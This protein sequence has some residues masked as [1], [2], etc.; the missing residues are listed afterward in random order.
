[1]FRQRLSKLSSQLY[2]YGL[3]P[4]GDS[5]LLSS[6]LLS[7]QFLCLFTWIIGM[8]FSLFVSPF[9]HTLFSSQEWLLIITVFVFVS[10]VSESLVRLEGLIHFQINHGSLQIHGTMS[11]VKKK[12]IA[13]YIYT[14]TYISFMQNYIKKNS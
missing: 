7:Y 11:L 8:D 6:P 12:S 14:Y 5:P 13:S 4:A 1:M 10:F 9:V 3:L 2:K